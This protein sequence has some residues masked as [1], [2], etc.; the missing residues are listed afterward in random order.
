[1]KKVKQIVKQSTNKRRTALMN[2]GISRL[3]TGA[4]D[5]ARTRDPLL[6]N[7]TLSLFPVVFEATLLFCAYPYFSLKNLFFDSSLKTI[8]AKLVP[9]IQE[10]LN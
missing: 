10:A 9:F 2:N 5:E 3:K 7:Y 4:G 1:M 6:G 8:S